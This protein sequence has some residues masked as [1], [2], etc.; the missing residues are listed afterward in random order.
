MRIN[1]PE[2][3]KKKFETQFC[4]GHR[5]ATTFFFRNKIFGLTADLSEI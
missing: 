1:A 4:T 5:T 2:G 3:L